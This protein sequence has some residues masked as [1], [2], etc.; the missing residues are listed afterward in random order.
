MQSREQHAR[1]RLDGAIKV[2]LADRNKFI[3]RI[4][5][6]HPHRAEQP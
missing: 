3:E 2:Q 1:H 6:D 4:L 5:R